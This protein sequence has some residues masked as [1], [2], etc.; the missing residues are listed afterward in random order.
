MTEAEIRERIGQY[1]RFPLRG[2]LNVV[3]DT[4]EFMRIKADDVLQLGGAYYLVTGEEVEGRFGLDGEPKFWVKRAVDL[5]DGSAR[6]IKLVFHESFVMQLGVQQ[7]KCF[8]SPGKESRIL[9]KTRGDPCFMQG[10]TVPDEVGNPVRVIDRIY[11]VRYYDYIHDLTIDH[12][13]YFHEQFPLLLRNLLSCF[14]AIQGLHR[15]D[16]LHGDI[17]NDHIIIEHESGVYRWIDF[18]YTYEWSENTFGVDLFGLGNVLLLTLG[19]GFHNLPDIAAC[20]PSGMKVISCLETADLSLFFRNRIINLKKLFP[21]IPDSLNEVMLH[22]SQGAEVFYERAEELLEDLE[23]CA[24][25]LPS[26]DGMRDGER[27]HRGP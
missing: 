19:K 23:A 11:G 9:E 27:S 26:V 8:R 2:K 13:T 20:G 18:D 15:M 3:T 5:S 12:E 14:R 17:R 10:F 4:T 24:A 22:F 21:Y 6:I 25:D 7:I 16:E 1:A